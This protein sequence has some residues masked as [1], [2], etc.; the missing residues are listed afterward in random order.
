M[1]CWRTYLAVLLNRFCNDCCGTKPNQV[2]TTGPVSQETLDQ[3]KEMLEDLEW[4]LI[5][6]T[7]EEV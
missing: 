6:D 4:R 5:F 3:E 2:V 1:S 7:E